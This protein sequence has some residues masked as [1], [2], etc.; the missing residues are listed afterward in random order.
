MVES[1]AA[2][3]RR[4][5]DCA[6]RRDPEPADQI[7]PRGTHRPTGLI[8]SALLRK[9]PRVDGVGE[10]DIS[11]DVKRKRVGIALDNRGVQAFSPREDKLIEVV[12]IDSLENRRELLASEAARELDRSQ[13]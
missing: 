10:S 11:R 4:N 12:G 6:A 13:R 3:S 9:P 5:V 1:V 7:R 8:R 2:P